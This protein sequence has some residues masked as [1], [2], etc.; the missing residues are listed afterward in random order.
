[1]ESERPGLRPSLRTLQPVRDRRRVHNGLV[2][3]DPEHFDIAF[4]FWHIQAA[5]GSQLTWAHGVLDSRP[6]RTLVIVNFHP[7]R[8]NCATEL[9][10]RR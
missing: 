1:M 2:T 8:L 10:P 6:E 3:R 7:A 4:F 5:A 9:Q